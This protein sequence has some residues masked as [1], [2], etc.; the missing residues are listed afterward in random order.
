[1]N[2]AVAS[3]VRWEFKLSRIKATHRGIPEKRILRPVANSLP[4]TNRDF[5]LHRSFEAIDAELTVS[6]LICALSVAPAS[7]FLLKS[8]LDYLEQENVQESQISIF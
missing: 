5:N 1:M 4:F 7:R 2:I 8:S 3:G 6:V